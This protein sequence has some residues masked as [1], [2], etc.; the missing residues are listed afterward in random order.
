LQQQLKVKIKAKSKPLKDWKVNIYFGVKTGYNEA[1]V[2]DKAK[3]DELVAKDSKSA[4]VIKPVLKGREVEKYITR[5]DSSYLIST[6]PSLKLNIDAYEQVKLF[7]ESFGRK[8][9]QVGENYIE[10]GISQT[11]RKKT[12][13]KWFE[14]QDTISF[15]QEFKKEKIIW[16]RIG[17]QLRFSY[18]DEELFC[19]DSTCIATGEKMKYLTAFLNSK[20]CH[21]ELFE[22]AP[23]SVQALEP[24]LAFYPTEQE[25]RPFID[26]VDK[27]L[28]GKKAGEDTQVLEAEI[29]LRVYKLYE[30]THAE[31]LVID[32]N[33]GMSAE[34]Y[35]L[36]AY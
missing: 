14:T 3:R 9:H 22:N 7:L 5:W 13:N 28:A 1:F 29:D 20:L 34:K 26:L 33:L 31:V 11:T 25:E 4:E 36:L 6:L 35:E 30:L 16:K 2:I 32:P 27:I 12:Q 19:L 17:S 8:L 15:Y 23:I 24:L 21:Y 10:D 18:S